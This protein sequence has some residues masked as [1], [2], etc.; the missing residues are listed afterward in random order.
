[1]KVLQINTLAPYN[2]KNMLLDKKIRFPFNLNLRNAF[3]MLSICQAIADNNGC[4]DESE[5]PAFHESTIR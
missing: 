4:T 5:I 3:K 1:M 2:D